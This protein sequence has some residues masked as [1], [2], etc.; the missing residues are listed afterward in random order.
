MSAHQSLSTK[1]HPADEVEPAAGNFR[2]LRRCLCLA[3]R[4]ITLEFFNLI[5]CRDLTGGEKRRR[6]CHARQI[7]M[8]LCHVSLGMRHGEIGT[9]FGRDR[10]TVGHAC[11]VVED[12][13][14]DPSYDVLILRLERLIRDLRPLADEVRR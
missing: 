1:T 14:D 8:Y 2:Q 5:S 7:A 3:V 4:E 12:R 11:H 6:L 9:V 10:S 13:R